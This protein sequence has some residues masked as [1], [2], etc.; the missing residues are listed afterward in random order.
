M[1]RS[2]QSDGTRCRRP[3]LGSGLL[4]RGWSLTI[5]FACWAPAATGGTSTA[6]SG[7]NC[8]FDGHRLSTD[9]PT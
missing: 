5:D 2:P 8:S 3:W 9:R 6:R 7:K 4:V 1:M